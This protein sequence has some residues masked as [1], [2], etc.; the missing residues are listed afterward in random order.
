MSSSSRPA[1]SPS[2][3]SA[4]ARSRWAS[5]TRSASPLACAASSISA[6]TG[7]RVDG[8]AGY[9]HRVVNGELRRRQRAAYR[10][11]A[12]AS[13]TARCAVLDDLGTGQAVRS[14]PH[15]RGPARRAPGTAGPAGRAPPPAAPRPRGAGRAARRSARLIGARAT[16]CPARPSRAPAASP[17]RAAGVG[18]LTEPLHRPGRSCPARS[19]ARGELEQDLGALAGVPPERRRSSMS[20]S[21][22]R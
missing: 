7:S 20:C 19:C 11:A 4:A 15:R 1:G 2:S 13:S 6:M 22:R 12:A 3:I 10:P 5:A 18:G 14:V 8:R 17:G 21:A 9:P 16:A